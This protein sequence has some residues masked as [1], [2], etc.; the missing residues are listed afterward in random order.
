MRKR[1][2]TE[3]MI[4]SQNRRRPRRAYQDPDRQRPQRLE[5]LERLRYALEQSVTLI[6]NKCGGSYRDV[7]DEDSCVFQESGVLREVAFQNYD[8]IQGPVSG[9]AGVDAEGD[10]TEH[11]GKRLLAALPAHKQEGHEFRSELDAADSR[12]SYL[13]DI[14]VLGSSPVPREPVDHVSQFQWEV[15]EPERRSRRDLVPLLCG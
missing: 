5:F 1:S 12:L 7:A 11:N 15:E 2:E 13:H 6:M 8:L 9:L 3:A 14:V 10:V 4:R